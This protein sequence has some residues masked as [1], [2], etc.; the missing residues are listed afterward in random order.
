M[1]G[2]PAP[3]STNP[4]AAARNVPRMMPTSCYPHVRRTRDL[5]KAEDVLERVASLHAG[6]LPQLV[7]IVAREEV[8]HRL[9]R[10]SEELGVVVDD[11]VVDPVGRDDGEA[12]NSV[13]R[14]T[15]VGNE[16]PE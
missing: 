11:F 4:T 2:D 5:S 15:V 9:E 7:S 13:H 8:P 3:R 10:T 14:V 16:P 1:T 6:L 12:F